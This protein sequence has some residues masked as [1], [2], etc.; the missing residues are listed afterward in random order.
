MEAALNSP[1]GRTVLG[2][3]AL[4]IGRAPDN[5][6]VLQDAQTSTRHAEI[7][8]SFDGNGYQV[9][10]L[11]STNGTF[12]NEQRLPPSTPYPLKAGDVIRVGQTK[13]TY[14]VSGTGYAPTV[15]ADSVPGYTPT[16]AASDPFAVPAQPAFQQPPSYG[17]SN[18]PAQLPYPPPPAYPQAAGFAQPQVQPVYPQPAGFVQPQGV[19]PQAQSVYPPPIYP[20]PGFGPTGMSQ[21]KSNTGLIIAIIVIVAVL[22]V[23]GTSVYFLT[24]STPQKTLANY[25]DAL[26]TGN[27]Q[28]LYNNL[29]TAQQ[30]KTSVSRMQ[31]AMNVLK[32]AGGVKECVVGSVQENG[33]SAIGSVTFTLSNGQSGTQTINLIQESGTWKL[34]TGSSVTPT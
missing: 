3:G 5:A 20:Q 16:V 9:T 21:K 1:L 14:E 7:A 26:K 23:G 33:S 2:S 31:Q 4:R 12:V 17:S 19:Y 34:D 11:D 28:E 15:L 24:R 29:D 30:L 25:C 8:P 13:I 10:D 6:L 27:A 32:A 22:V 18:T